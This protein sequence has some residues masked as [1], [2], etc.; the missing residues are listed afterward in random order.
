MGLRKDIWRSA[1]AMAPIE[2]IVTQGSLDGIELIWLPP[3]GS[4]RFLADPFG[5]W[6]DGH[7]H[8]FVEAYDYRVR[9]GTIEVLT[10]DGDFRLLD[11]QPALSRSWHLSYPFLVEDGGEMWMLP[12][13]QR[14]GQLTLYR[15]VRW[16]TSWEPAWDIPLDTVGIDSSP[17]FHQGLW[18]LFYASSRSEEDKMG[19]LHCA[20]AEHLRGPWTP[21]P[22]N[23]VRHDLSGARPGGTPYV[24]SGEIVLPVQDCSRTYGGAISALRITVSPTSFTARLD[25]AILPPASA[26]P[27]V[28]GLHTLSAAGA[29]TLVD[30][31]RTELSAHGL[32][33]E[34]GRE[35]GKLRR[36]LFGGG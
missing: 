20:W 12:E 19:T 25:P 11:R 22:L 10:Y 4:F 30:M 13:G 2:R 17:I 26:A 31:K 1:I 32:A 36:W 24:D 16:P 21:H 33:I 23:P 35:A 14:S 5:W 15:C 28:E 9:R 34:L 18:W 3:M 7:L 29:V 8:V 6:R 27:F